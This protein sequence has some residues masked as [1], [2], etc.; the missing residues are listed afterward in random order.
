MLRRRL[1][2]RADVVCLRMDTKAVTRAH[3]VYFARLHVILS[4]GDHLQ[5]I[6]VTLFFIAV[7]LDEYCLCGSETTGVVMTCEYC[8]REAG[9][10]NY[11]R[12]TGAEAESSADEEEEEAA[13]P[14]K[15]SCSSD[16]APHDENQPMEVTAADVSADADTHADKEHEGRHDD[17]EHTDT[18]AD[19]EN[20]VRHDEIEHT[21]AHADTEHAD[22]HSEG[23][24]AVDSVSCLAAENSVAEDGVEPQS[25]G[26]NFPSNTC[27]KTAAVVTTYASEGV[28]T[29]QQTSPVLSA[30][31]QKLE[32]QVKRI[33]Q[34]KQKE[35][36]GNQP[37]KPDSLS[38]ATD[39]AALQDFSER[40]QIESTRHADFS[41]SE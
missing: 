25:S 6:V 3:F 19:K 32:Q 39:T 41:E 7:Y 17:T 34:S 31:Q 36:A 5:M 16:G 30:Q 4:C 22:G 28:A 37:S 10:W 9:A 13:P 1:K 29:P 11:T 27:L 18:H 20:E 24:L 8:L 2:I 26:E 15:Q 33:L 40:E 12:L 38:S 21:D 14:K 35:Q 23:E